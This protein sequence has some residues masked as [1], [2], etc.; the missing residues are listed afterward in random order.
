MYC[1]RF[2]T[3]KTCMTSYCFLAHIPPLT[4]Q[5]PQ[6]TK[7]H[8][9]RHLT[10]S[11]TLIALQ[12]HWLLYCPSDLPICSSWIFSD[13]LC[14][15]LSLFPEFSFPWIIFF[16]YT[17]LIQVSDH[18][19]HQRVLHWTLSLKHHSRI[20]LHHYS[21]LFFLYSNYYHLENILFPYFFT[22]CLLLLVFKLQKHGFHFACYCFFS[23]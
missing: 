6:K 8:L 16:L 21:V 10:S 2:W 3:F 23:D 11:T 15:W 18:I 20:P 12:V 9:W 13:T 19:L 5:L 1:D 7:I 4:L 22:V 14:A 17:P